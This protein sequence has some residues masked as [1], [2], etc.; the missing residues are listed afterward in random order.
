[1]GSEISILALISEHKDLDFVPFDTTELQVPAEGA[2]LVTS[3]LRVTEIGEFESRLRMAC[4]VLV[5]L[6]V[7]FLR[8][9]P[10]QAFE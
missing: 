7:F 8:V 10:Q 3:N 9:S 5:W 6:G 1:M 2:N 4:L